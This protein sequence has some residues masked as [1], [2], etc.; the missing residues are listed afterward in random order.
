[1]SGLDEYRRKRN[2]KRTREPA[3]DG[4]GR[5]TRSHER[6][7]LFVVHKHAARRL[8]Y[9]LR[10]ERDGVLESWAVPK[11]PSMEVGAKRLA[12]HVEDH[13]LDYGDFEGT[14]PKNEY[15]GGTVMLWDRGSWRE[16]RRRDG[17]I[18]FELAGQKLHGTWSLTRMGKSGNGKGENWLLIKRSD[19]GST[20]GAPADPVPRDRSV[21]SGRTMRQIANDEPAASGRERASS[22]ADEALEISGSRKSA[23]PPRPRAQLATL[24]EKPPEGQGWLQEIKFD[25]YRIL[26]MVDNDSVSLWSRNG[27]NWTARFPAIAAR[28][29]ALPVSRLLIDGEVVAL[30]PDGLSSF[31]R[32][33]EMLS[34]GATDAAV[35]QAFDLLHVDGVDLAGAALSDRKNMLRGVL[36]PLDPSAAVRFTGHVPGDASRF[37]DKACELGLEGIICKRA[38]ARYRAV[39]NRDWLK[40]KCVR[41]EE[42]I[43][44][45]YTD[46]AG[47][48]TGFGALLLGAK[49]TGGALIYAGKVGTGFNERQLAGLHAAL[50]RLEK[51]TCPFRDCPERR[52]VHWVEPLLVAEVAFTEWTRDGRLRHPVFRGLREDKDPEEIRMPQPAVSEAKGNDVRRPRTKR[53]GAEVAGVALTTADRVL[54]PQQGITKLDLARY[55]EEM[56]DWILPQIR[57]RPLSLLRCPEGHGHECFFQKHPGQAISGDIPRVSIRE[58][59]GNA[60]YLY[61]ERLRDL[62]ALVQAGTLELHAWGCTVDDVERPDMVVFDLDPGPGVDWPEVLDAARSLHDRLRSLKLGA[63]I[64]TTGGKGLHVVVPLRPG[65]EWDGIKAFAKAVAAVHA[66]EDP[67]RFT[68][69]MS[70]AR[71]RRRIFIDYLRNGRGNTA[72]VS[73]STRA[74]EGAPVAVPVRRDELRPSLKGNHYDIETV[75]RRVR[76][77]SGDPWQRFEQERRPLTAATLRALGLKEGSR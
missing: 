22:L 45:G 27:K 61:I 39:R 28:L 26:A 47:T 21:S 70:K 9:D 16:I 59:S 54:Y 67:G 1:M 46:P 7:R 43:I 65:A 8:H 60:E 75:R 36:E 6:E 72:I 4:S 25:G 5:A 18:D 42:L 17:L 30:Q 66:R 29:A 41:H 13:P 20:G 23:L 32:L 10:L 40:V 50:S 57:R 63:F 35:Y 55:Y 19:P 38:A 53:G 44:G 33:Q 74:R 58:K 64:R 31:R 76:S 68:I 56:A 2:F 77:L 12:I 52:G 11:G 3:G 34:D 73:Y 69:N 71:R 24:V 62:V 48:R 51:N 49:D 15:G 37:Y 14:I